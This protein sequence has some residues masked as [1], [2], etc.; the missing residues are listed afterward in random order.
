VSWCGG[1]ERRRSRL[2]A[3]HPQ[4]SSG[5]P[6][7]CAPRATD[8]PAR[9]VR[10]YGR[11]RDQWSARGT[12]PHLLRHAFG[13]HIARHAGMRNA[14][15]LLG[16][17]DVGTTES[18]VGRPTLDELARAVAG[19]TF[20]ALERAFSPSAVRAVNLQIAR[21]PARPVGL[22]RREAL[23]SGRDAVA[24]CREGL[25]A[26]RR[27]VGHHRV[28]QDS[29]S[30]PVPPKSSLRCTQKLAPRS[31]HGCWPRRFTGP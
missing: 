17:A 27:T 11:R 6:A 7:R 19:F 23:R 22:A 1:P 10:T 20:G 16:H 9:V 15:F 18:Y 25:E 4:P 3:R 2:T 8:A 26:L 29:L 30:S 21:K 14:Q 12:H 28:G 5:M 31:S 13:D 24:D